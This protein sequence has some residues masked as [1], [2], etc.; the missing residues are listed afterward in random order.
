MLIV[1]PGKVIRVFVVCSALLVPNTIGLAQTPAP[2]PPPRNPAQR[3]ATKPPGSEQNPTCATGNSA[4]H[5]R[6]QSASQFAAG[7]G[8][9]AAGIECC[10]ANV[11]A[12][13]SPADPPTTQTPP[14]TR[15]HAVTRAD[16]QCK[17]R[18]SQNFPWRNRDRCPP[19]QI[20]RVSA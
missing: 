5:S 15:D 13:K 6:S 8:Q 10:A 9:S 7:S 3:D 14:T 19:C 20:L 11:H 16:Q 1:D 4:Q 12:A 18:K 17:S 2:T